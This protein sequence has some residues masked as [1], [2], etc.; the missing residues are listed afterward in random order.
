MNRQTI[1]EIAAGIAFTA[2][3]AMIFGWCFLVLA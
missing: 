1:E 3:M 2:L